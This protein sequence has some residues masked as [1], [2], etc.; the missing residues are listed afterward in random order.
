VRI[1]HLTPGTGNFYCGSC[2][3][4]NALVRALRARGHDVLMVPLY[5][6]FVTDEPEATGSTPMFFGGINVYLQQRSALFRH[7]PPWFD[8]LFD[9]PAMLQRAVERA[10]MT[11][12]RELG[13]ITLSMLHGEE[14][15]QAKE[16]EKLIVWL[17]SQPKPDVVCL[18]NVLLVGLVRRI[19]RELGV[20]VVSTLQG[21]DSFLDALPAPERV[22]AWKL[23]SERAAELDLCIATSRYFADVMTRRLRLPDSR[24]VVVHNGIP[25]D[26]FAPAESLP[27]PPALGYLARMCEAK[28]LRPLV[29]AFIELKRRA[30]IPGLRLRVA[31]AMTAGDE[32]FVSTLRARIEA[33][34]L[35]AET[36]WLPN[37]ERLHKQAF[38]RGV[39][40]LSVP[41]TYGEAFGLYLLEAWASGVPVVQPRS[42][43]FPELIE[44]TGGGLLCEPDHPKALADAIESLLQNPEKTREL[45]ERGRRAVHEHFTVERMAQNVEDVLRRVVAVQ[46]SG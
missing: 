13:A 21:E 28:G 5:L 26:G 9:S 15:H 12:A 30:T 39:S 19:R 4:D 7:T 6:P 17:T 16:L 2:L 18:S 31:G 38:L 45:G 14:G 41:A 11:R 40:V 37:I 36:E 20:P 29:S 46:S 44:K 43:A 3:R 33:E 32:S 34:A 22:E 42:G 25:L 35:S 24:V 1:V 27:N 23:L 10:G 8:R